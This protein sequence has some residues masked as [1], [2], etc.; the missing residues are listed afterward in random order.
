MLLQESGT[1]EM[2]Q[3]TKRFYAS[4]EIDLR[5]VDKSTT[6]DNYK[7]PVGLAC[8]MR[9][10]RCGLKSSSYENKKA[11]STGSSVRN[12]KVWYWTPWRT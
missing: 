2:L 1:R 10:Q 6:R 4:I 8:A 5:N 9:L 11:K 12:A 3:S 7:D